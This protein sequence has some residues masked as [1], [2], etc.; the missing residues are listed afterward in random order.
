MSFFK[1]LM[2]LLVLASIFTTSLNSAK[3]SKYTKYEI[4]KASIE[5]KIT[6]VVTGTETLIFDQFGMREKKITKGTVNQGGMLQQ[7]HV[8]NYTLIDKYYDMSLLNKIGNEYSMQEMFDYAD[9]VGKKNLLD[10]Q[11]DVFVKNGFTVQDGGKILGKVTEKLTAPNDMVTMWLWKN[12]PLKVIRKSQVG[13]MVT[14]ATKINEK[15]K[16]TKTTFDLPKD[17]TIEKK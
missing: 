6:G 15:P 13:D 17:V 7:I 1:S 12:I 16:I 11:Y 3:N 8:A 4:E 2:A 5:Y 14:E 9:S 10:I